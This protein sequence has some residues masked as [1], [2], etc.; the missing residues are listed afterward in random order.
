MIMEG[1]NSLPFSLQAFGVKWRYEG[2]DFHFSLQRREISLFL[3]LEDK[4]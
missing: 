1:M 2:C 4:N 3:S